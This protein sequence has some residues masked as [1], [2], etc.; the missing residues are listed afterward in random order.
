M[1]GD[2]LRSY[3]KR[4]HSGARIFAEDVPSR[5]FNGRAPGKPED[6]AYNCLEGKPYGA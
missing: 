6:A 4:G 1:L 3:G 2:I 5:E